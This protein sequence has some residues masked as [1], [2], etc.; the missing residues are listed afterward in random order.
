MKKSVLHITIAAILSLS[1]L[2]VQADGT[3]DKKDKESKNEK[4]EKIVNS[5]EARFDL[6]IK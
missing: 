4:A 2:T 6:E 5:I 3:K 1:F